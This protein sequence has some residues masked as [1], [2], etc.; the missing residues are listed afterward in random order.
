VGPGES[1][2]ELF[3]EGARLLLRQRA[4]LRGIAAYEAEHG[5][6]SAQALA[7]ADAEL[8]AAGVVDNTHVGAL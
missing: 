6:I 7:A 5:Q 4:A 8:D 2:S 3:S 1:L